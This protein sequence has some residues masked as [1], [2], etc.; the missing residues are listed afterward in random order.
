MIIM[1]RSSWEGNAEDLVPTTPYLHAFKWKTAKGQV[2]LPAGGQN[3]GLYVP[4]QSDSRLFF[5]C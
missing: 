1:K 2:F 5:L 4:L 3:V